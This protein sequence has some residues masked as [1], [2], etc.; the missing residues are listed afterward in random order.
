MPLRGANTRELRTK[1]SNANGSYSPE[2]QVGDEA[3][4]DA[5][6][7]R[8][9]ERHQ[10][11]GQEGG[12]GLLGIQPIN[13]AAMLKHHGADDHDCGA[14]GVGRNAGK[15]GREEHGDAEADG[16]DERGEAGAAAL[17]DADG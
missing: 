12:D 10:D 6:G 16:D 13:V 9:G 7:D 11:D 2:E 3:S 17:L 14:G 15:D 8:V 1:L 4:D 5:V